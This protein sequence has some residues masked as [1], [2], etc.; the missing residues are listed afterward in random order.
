MDASVVSR[1]GGVGGGTGREILE[2]VAFDDGFG[3]ILS[4]S[5]GMKI[6]RCGFMDWLMS[7]QS[8]TRWLKYFR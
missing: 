1:V 8:L 5:D 2:V 7:A 3:G 4:D 6:T